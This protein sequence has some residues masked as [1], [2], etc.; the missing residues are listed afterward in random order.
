MT[1]Q[2][3]APLE[4]TL[5]TVRRPDKMV[6]SPA[7]LAEEEV[8]RSKTTVN[9]RYVIFVRDADEH[10][11]PMVHSHIL[12]PAGEFW[13][14]ESREQIVRTLKA[15]STA[16]LPFLAKPKPGADGGEAA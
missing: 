13:V 6:G 12:T 8:L 11:A 9:W 3:G 1:P 10:S 5:V 14:A 16:P 15:V 7:L 2:G 4:V